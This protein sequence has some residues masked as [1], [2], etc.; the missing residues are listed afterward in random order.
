MNQVASK[1]VGRGVGG[2]SRA[3]DVDHY[4][5]LR[6]RQR[7]IMLGLTQQQ[8]A[9]L[10]GV[11]YQQAHKYETGINRI[12]AGRLYQIAQALGVEIGY[13]FEEVEP[14]RQSRPKQ[15]ELMPQQRM[16]LELARNFANIQ[17]RKHQDA[18]CNLAR[19]LSSSPVVV[20]EEPA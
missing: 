13:F 16:L 3:L 9:E 6:I 20:A 1:V 19:V 17:N 15:T 10:I 5:S 7:R 18:L 12:S 14:D 4:V 11:T 8:M 2:R